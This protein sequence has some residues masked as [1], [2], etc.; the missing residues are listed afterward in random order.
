MRLAGLVLIS[1]A[2]AASSSVSW[3]PDLAGRAD[4]PR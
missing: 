2:A 4:P 1:A 3:R